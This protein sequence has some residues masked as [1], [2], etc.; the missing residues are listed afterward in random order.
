LASES[1]GIFSEVPAFRPLR[2]DVYEALREAILLGHLAP[3]ERVVEAELAR[4]M[5]I[6]R[7]PIREALRQLEQDGLVDYRPRRGVI[8]T[9][10]TPALILDAYAVRAALEGLAASAAARHASPEALDSLEALLEDMRAHARAG[11][12][13]ALQ[14]ADVRFHELICTLAENPVLLKSWRG[15]GPGSWTLFSIGKQEGSYELTEIAERHLPIVTAIRSG[16]AEEALAAAK[17]HTLAVGHIVASA[18]DAAET[19]A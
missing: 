9:A 14:Q 12:A 11:D 10:L 15:L 1:R 4:Q 18:L 6:S 13:V 19:R 5:R 17:E 2:R 3:G 8:V 7:G 16:E